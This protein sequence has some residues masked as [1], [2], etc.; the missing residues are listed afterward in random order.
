[1]SRHPLDDDR[2]DRDLLARFAFDE[3]RFRADRDAILS[4]RLTAGSHTVQGPIE[5]APEVAVYDA[6][7]EAARAAGEAALRAGEVA[8]V[9]LNGGMATRFGGVVKGVVEVFDGKSFIALK[10][11]DTRRAAERFGAP[12]PF[13]LM[14]SFATQ[15]ATR[16]HVQSC[17]RFGL[18]EA[19]VL[20]FEQSI[21]IR[22]N[23]DGSLFIGDD[24]KPSYHAPGHGDFFACI[25]RSGVLETLRGRGVKY[26]LFSNV[27]NLGATVDP[28]VIGRHVLSEK[29]MTAEVTQKQR[30]AS[31]KWDKG[32][33]PA[34]LESGR[35]QVVE[36]FRFPADFPQEKLPDFSTNNMI[37]SAEAVER[38][39]PL[40]RYLVEK[41]V[42]GR[43][44]LQLETITC[45]ASASLD[46]D[47]RPVFALGLLRVPREGARGRFYPVKEPVDLDANRGK[48]KERLE[49][50]WS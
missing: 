26:L 37:F 22:M 8:S 21:S 9:V 29:T 32:G 45:E 19:Q 10:A 33:A 12:V 4:G 31:G 35:V 11:E 3:A 44:A 49:A 34:L 46:P 43:P 20:E 17:G 7:D 14:N 15:G 41:K 28:W 38:D 39:V 40:D 48:L 50:A 42:D 23:P 25:R 16:E 5:P 13:V 24:G 47:G 18:E 36:G 2:I 30:T 27:D 6:E 1:M